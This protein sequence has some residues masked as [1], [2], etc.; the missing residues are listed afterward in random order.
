ML[1]LRIRRA[2]V[3]VLVEPGPRGTKR[4]G[5]WQAQLTSI[6]LPRSDYEHALAVVSALNTTRGPR[7]AD[8]DA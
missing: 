4:V 5:G 1:G 6:S 2:F 3:L 7:N 8:F